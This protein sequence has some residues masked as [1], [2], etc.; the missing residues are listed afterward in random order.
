MNRFGFVR[1]TCASTRTVVADPEANAA[2]VVRVLA[3]VPESDVVV[4]PELC[5]TAY[6]CADLF[7]QTAL[8]GA[9][10]RALGEVAVATRGRAQLVLVGLPV[11]VGNS[12]YNTAAAVSDGAV[13]GAVPKQFLPNYK[14]FYE[15]RWFSPANGREPRSVSLAGG[16]VPRLIAAGVVDAVG[17]ECRDRTGERHGDGYGES[18]LCCACHLNRGCIRPGGEAGG[19]QSHV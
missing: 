16:D 2:E 7:G 10:E 4:F 11:R 14:E 17:R 1:I 18:G 15:A 12:L 6:T 13:I 9:A 19:I 8:L 3:E 5:L